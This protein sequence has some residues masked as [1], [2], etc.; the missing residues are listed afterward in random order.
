[1]KYNLS[2]FFLILAFCNSEAQYNRINGRLCVSSINPHYLQYEDGTP[3]FWLG[4]TGWEMFMRLSREEAAFYIDHRKEQGFNIIQAVLISE[5]EGVKGPDFYGSFPFVDGDPLKPLI[6]RGS[7]PDKPG[8]YDY[9]D[10]VDY[11]VDHAE[12][13]GMYLALLPAWGEYVIPREGKMIFTTSDIAYKYGWFLGNRY[14]E[15]KNIVWML[16]GDRQPDERPGGAEIWRSMAEGIAD[17]TNG[18]TGLD[19]KAD[20]STTC[21]TYHSF[22][23]SSTWFHGDPWIDFHS[24]GSY[25]SDFYLSR[26][27]EQA[28]SDWNLKDPKP[29]LNAEPAYEMHSV[30]WIEGNGYFSGCDV[31]DIA[32]WS[33]FA[34]SCGYTYGNNNVWQFYNERHKPI[35]FANLDWKKALDSPGALEVKY[36]KNLIGSRPMM[37]MEPDDSVIKGVNP[38]GAD[39]IQAIRGKS[40]MFI[41]I[42]TGHVPLIRLG[43]ISGNF[44]K[45]WWYNPRNGSATIIGTF[46]NKGEKTFDIP[47][48]SKD[49]DW[50]RTGRGCD[51]VLVIDDASKGFR[52]PGK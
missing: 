7:D 33:V 43:R 3:F 25:H 21:M 15:K 20:Y 49:L 27:Y 10:H 30:N 18:V 2:L 31:R 50:L 1:M 42:P 45:V 26:S 35:N 6:T 12:N 46:E 8:E 22:S 40:H 24:W 51:W 23:S 52:E 4:D 9:W 36:L 48:I 5:F 17:G 13:E 11:I 29:T 41:Y 14:R 44:V 32:Y 37:E 19:G 39:H 28:R 34:G 16:G 47:G 38:S